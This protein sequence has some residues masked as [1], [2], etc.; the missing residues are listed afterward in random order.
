M[1]KEELLAQAVKAH[2]EA[3]RALKERQAAFRRA[4]AGTVSVR[5]LSE[6]TG[7]TPDKIRGIKGR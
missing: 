7:L 1:N 3:E 2:I 5:E 6:A 4:T